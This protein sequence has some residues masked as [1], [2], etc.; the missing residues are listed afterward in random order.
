MKDFIFQETLKS[1]V[2][3]LRGERTYEQV[4][5]DSNYDGSCV[6]HKN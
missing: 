3:E 4:R 1:V 6:E 2:V 5:G